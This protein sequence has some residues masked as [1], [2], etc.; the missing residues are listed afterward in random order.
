[1]L[2]VYGRD[3]IKYLNDETAGRMTYD[4]WKDKILRQKNEQKIKSGNEIN[5]ATKYF[6]SSYC[7][8]R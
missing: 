2:Y 3:Y 7:K 1:M 8:C 5:A 4:Q 6:D